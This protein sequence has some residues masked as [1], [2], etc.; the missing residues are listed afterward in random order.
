MFQIRDNRSEP[1]KCIKIESDSPP[2]CAYCTEVLD[3]ENTKKMVDLLK[4]KG[5]VIP[6][7]GEP[8]CM[9]LARHFGATRNDGFKCWGKPTQPPSKKRKIQ[10]N[11]SQH[12]SQDS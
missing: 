6:C 5:I 1:F 9:L 11:E 2:P 10:K 7:C 4:R 12:Q 3:S 8:R